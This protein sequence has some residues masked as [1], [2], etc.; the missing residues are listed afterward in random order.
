LGTGLQSARELSPWSGLRIQARQ[1]R[2]GR[3]VRPVDGAFVFPLPNLTGRGL[4]PVYLERRGRYATVTS[5]K[6]LDSETLVCASFLER[7]LYLVR[8]DIANRTHRILDA[9]PTT[10]RGVPV[11]TDL[12]DSDP[13]GE[14]IVVS[15]F[16]HGSVGQYRREGERLRF[17]ADL[18]LGLH[19]KVHGVKF[20]TRDLVAATIGMAPT[21]VRFFDLA[22]GK[23][24]V[25]V[26]LPL[27]TQDVAFVSQREMIVLAVRGAP[28][29]S[30]QR[31]YGSDVCRVT[32]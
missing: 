13:S 28:R 27:K 2:R 29:R 8:F 23:P 1:A 16:H 14:H 17:V 22:A 19:S 31:P 3:R 30:E 24:T 32:A 4:R 20:M 25:H 10:Y 18:A 5:V 11:E 6:L 12:A 15:N 21:G 9:I 26:A 7:E